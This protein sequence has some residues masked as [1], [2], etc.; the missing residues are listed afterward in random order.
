MWSIGYAGWDDENR[1]KIRVICSLPYHALFIRTMLIRPTS[2][3]L[4]NF[5][6]PDYTIFNAGAFPANRFTAGMTSRTSVDL[7]FEDREMVIL[8]TEYAGE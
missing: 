3:D 6:T 4:L 7:S 1:I 8:G 2:E 5:G